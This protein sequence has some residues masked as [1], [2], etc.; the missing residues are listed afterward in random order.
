[1]QHELV[2]YTFSWDQPIW[3]NL[4]VWPSQNTLLYS[5]TKN[6]VNLTNLVDLTNLVIVS[7]NDEVDL[8]DQAVKLTWFLIK[9]YSR[10]L[11]DGQTTKF[12]QIGW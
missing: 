10:V 4:V 9:L 12:C 11:C 8:N 1:M 2:K 6:L 5:L 7:K 3:Q